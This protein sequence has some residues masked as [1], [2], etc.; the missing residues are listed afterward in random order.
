M[1]NQ[2]LHGGAIRF[3][4]ELEGLE[5]AGFSEVQGLEAET[6]IEE[7]REGGMNGFVH[8][9]PKGIRHPRI[10]LRKGLTSSPELWE[11]Y[12]ESAQGATVRRRKSGSII[13]YKSSYKE[14]DSR[15]NGKADQW[16]GTLND[17]IEFCRWN[18]FDAYPVKWVGPSMNALSS[19]MAIETVELVHNG[20]KL[21]NR[22]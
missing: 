8:R 1:N 21:I 17:S 9:L 3:G 15:W 16:R 20:I 14:G 13:L 12:N 4:I 10:V 19:D 5:V 7:Y 11:W 18:F 2:V 22:A 6:E